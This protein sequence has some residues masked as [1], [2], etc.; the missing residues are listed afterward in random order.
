MYDKRRL[1]TLDHIF[2]SIIT[3]KQLDNIF[4]QNNDDGKLLYI[5]SHTKCIIPEQSRYIEHARTCTGPTSYTQQYIEMFIAK[6]PQKT[7]I[8]HDT[9]DVV[10]NTYEIEDEQ[11]II[12]MYV[13]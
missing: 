3:L 9:N 1:L 11:Q 5:N 8:Q 6:H 4:V 12:G 13:F 2:T 10:S 7:I